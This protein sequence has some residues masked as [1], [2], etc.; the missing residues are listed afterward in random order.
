M[1][2][3]P[4][5]TPPSTTSE[6]AGRFILAQAGPE[7][8]YA[9]HPNPLPPD[10]PLNIGAELHELLDRGNQALGRLDGITLLLPD[11]GQFL[12]SY[13]RK[14]AVLSSQIEGTQSSLSDLLLFEQDV[15]PGVPIGDVEETANYIKALNH[16]LARLGEGF[17]LSNRLICEVHALLLEGGRGGE[18]DPGEFRRTQNWIG[19]TRPGNATFV[20][21]PAHE[22]KSAIG[23]LEKFI[24]DDPLPTPI[25]I[26]A[27]LAHAQ[28][29]T[30]HPFL[31]GNGR[32]GRLLITLLLCSQRVLSQPLLYLSLYLK[33]NRSE[34]YDHLQRIR[35]H[36]DWEAW[37]RFFLEGI[38]EVAEGA[39][40]TTRDIVAMIERDRTR[41]HQLG[42]TAS[43]PLRLHDYAIRRILVRPPVAAHALGVSEPTAYKAVGHLEQLGILREITGKNWGKV[44]AYSEYLAILNEGTEREAET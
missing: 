33:R 23:L 1:A 13:I 12:Y 10:P 9:F 34:Y 21:P 29:E 19:G 5:K 32:V 4:R 31:D 16:G 42:R 2:S 43:T 35:Y 39:T 7:P 6:R 25:L 18:Q 36:G 20:P 14:E 8:Y 22:A 30:I 41:I 17:P 11:P 27:A 24:H 44:Y 3:E 15:A 37:L 40:A 26:K 38:A 28:F